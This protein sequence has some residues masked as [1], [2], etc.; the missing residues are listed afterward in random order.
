MIGVAPAEKR[1]EFERFK[2]SVE[3][4]AEVCCQRELRNP[5][6]AI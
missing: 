4:V 2:N 3:V 1:F 6:V 5:D